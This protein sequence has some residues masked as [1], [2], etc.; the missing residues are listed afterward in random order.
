V[1][2]GG[3][4]KMLKDIQLIIKEIEA[5]RKELIEC[6]HDFDDPEM[7]KRSQQLDELINRYY[8]LLEDVDE[9]KRAIL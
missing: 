1:S 4:T 3:F 5:R 6:G 2:R 9:E 7:L 8:K